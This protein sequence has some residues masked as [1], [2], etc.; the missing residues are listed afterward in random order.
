M[1]DENTREKEIQ[2]QKT[3]EKKNQDS[4]QDDVINHLW[5]LN[6]VNWRD[7]LWHFDWICQKNQN[8]VLI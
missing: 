8:Q 4:K 3:L 1:I 2:D 6:L 7:Y 5:L